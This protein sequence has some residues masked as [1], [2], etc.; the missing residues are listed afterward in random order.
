MCMHRAIHAEPE[1]AVQFRFY[2]FKS[3]LVAESPVVKVI[4]SPPTQQE[5][6]TTQNT[7]A[8]LQDV[9][10]EPPVLEVRRP[11]NPES[12]ILRINR[13]LCFVSERDVL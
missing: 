9:Q 1:T 6:Q 12:D 5:R 13:K 4:R 11:M 2:T 10:N 8:V 7:P 3:H